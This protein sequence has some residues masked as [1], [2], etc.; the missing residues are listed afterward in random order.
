MSSAERPVAFVAGSQLLSN[1]P[2]QPRQFLAR[3][4]GVARPRT[5]TGT[6]SVIAQTSYSGAVCSGM[7]AGCT[8]TSAVTGPEHVLAHISDAARA[9]DIKYGNHKRNRPSCRTTGESRRKAE[10]RDERARIADQRNG[11]EDPLSEQNEQ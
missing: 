10:V 2:Q 6:L 5:L 3:R 11:N 8:R 4:I 1:L 9:P 7:S